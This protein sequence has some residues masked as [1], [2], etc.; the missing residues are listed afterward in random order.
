LAR[1]FAGKGTYGVKE[2]QDWKERYA[3]R[4]LIEAT[5]AEAETKG[6]LESTEDLCCNVVEGLFVLLNSIE[7]RTNHLGMSSRVYDLSRSGSRG[8]RVVGNLS[9]V[10]FFPDDS[11]AAE[12]LGRELLYDNRT[13]VGIAYTRQ[14]LRVLSQYGPP[15]GAVA[16]P[17][18]KLLTLPE[19][20]E[21]EPFSGAR[22][23]H[24]EMRHQ[25]GALLKAM[26]EPAEQGKR[27]NT[28]GREALP[29]LLAFIKEFR[30]S[31]ERANSRRSVDVLASKYNDPGQL[32][33]VA[34]ILRRFKSDDATREVDLLRSVSMDKLRTLPGWK[35]LSGT[36]W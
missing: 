30:S 12:Q 22:E 15:S 33:L 32:A 36:P 29:V 2:D 4:R 10:L 6:G 14:L 31:V 26:Q 3:F 35:G 28:G 9:R 34:E 13:L 5:Q 21:A 23:Q 24:Y 17:I 27:P 7:P 18:A 19:L 20:G 1:R 11:K 16:I 8:F 25:A